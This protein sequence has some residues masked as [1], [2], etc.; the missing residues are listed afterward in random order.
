MFSLHLLGGL[1]LEG[2]ENRPLG[3]GLQRRRLALLAVL[4][5][6]TRK[7]ATRDALIALLW[8]ESTAEEA[9]HRLSSALYDLRGTLGADAFRCKNDEVALSHGHLWTDVEEFEGALLEGRWEA[10]VSAY[11]GPFLEGNHFGVGEE[12]D[13]WADGV[14]DRLGRSFQRALTEAGSHALTRGDHR[15]AVEYF[16]RR[17]ALT[18]YD[19]ETT[20]ALMRALNA[21]GD[22]A[23]AL[24]VAER[25]RNLLHQDLRAFPS[26]EV[27]SLEAELRQSPPPPS[28]VSPESSPVPPD[29]RPDAAG[30]QRPRRVSSKV[31]AAAALLVVTCGMLWNTTREVSARA[32]HLPLRVA[33]L[34]FRVV[35]PVPIANLSHGLVDLLSLDLDG[36]GELRTVDPGA[37]LAG[38]DTG[39][40]FT[41]QA[42]RDR[43]R[44]L[45]ADRFVSGSVLG[46]AGKIRIRATLY[47]TATGEAEAEAFAEG[48]PERFLELVDQVGTTLLAGRLKSSGER[49]ARAGAISTHSLPALKSW[50]AGELA[51]RVGRYHEAAESFE[52]ATR[53]DSAFALAHYR[54]SLAT[55]WGDRPG[56]STDLHDAAAVRHAETL[57]PRERRLLEAYTAWREGN[58]A[59]AEYQYRRIIALWPDDVEAW[60]Q[61]GETLFHYNPLRGRP[62]A[63]ARQAFEHVLGLDPGHGGAEWHLALLHALD[64][65]RDDFTR[66]LQR[67]QHTPPDNA[68][69]A[70]EIQALLLETGADPEVADNDS[71]L[72]G[73]DE[74]TLF[75]L[76]WRMGVFLGDLEGAERVSRR[77]LDPGRNDYIRFL[78]HQNL[79]LIAAAR[80]KL[81]AGLAEL[82][83]SPTPGPDLNP[84][85]T[86]AG[87]LTYWWSGFP[88]GLRVAVRD[89]LIRNPPASGAITAPVSTFLLGVLNLELGDSTGFADAL[90]RLERVTGSPMPTRFLGNELRGLAA[91][92]A[93]RNA[94]GLQRLTL[95]GPLGWFGLA[96][97]G[98][99]RADPLFRFVRAEALFA[100]G[101]LDEAAGW[102]QSLGEHALRDLVYLAPAHFRRGEILERQGRTAEAREHF[103]AVVSLWTDAD[104][105]LQPWVAAARARLDNRLALRGLK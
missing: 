20:L 79:A 87:L 67:L 92:R 18:P 37:I 56:A 53:F 12:F 60:Q 50:L 64:G 103:A 40:T 10:A 66:G 38:A 47:V 28:P 86:A 22:T 48:S 23:D 26:A 65:K 7:S 34:P 105:E 69:S 99:V 5:M 81:R 98:D 19:G 58:A 80:G 49:L 85:I 83:T 45:G 44:R 74:N 70:S 93:G 43:A 52:E 59:S 54:H 102:Y 90:A 46:G 4:S 17:S 75:S 95:D 39:S 82:G 101:R 89:S 55:L 15:A 72:Q 21:G 11:A 36:A 8:P 33:V 3:R 88:T 84:G 29:P 14:R 61:L 91:I 13:R 42:G 68:A 25:H 78:G 104:P 35:G 27:A 51:F 41:E 73:A 100:L 94:E 2:F 30:P 24:L 97:S 77:L 9:R 71:A 76:A 57:G 96:V 1:H 63:E 32:S 16:R 6:A 31:L 62:V